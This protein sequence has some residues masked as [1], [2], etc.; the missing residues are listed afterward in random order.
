MTTIH[1][2]DATVMV[3]YNHNGQNQVVT[4]PS[5]VANNDDLLKQALIAIVPWASNARVERTGD[6]ITLVKV[7]A[8]TNG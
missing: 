8:G 2:V 1:A 7:G 6:K 4:V 5:A 3:H